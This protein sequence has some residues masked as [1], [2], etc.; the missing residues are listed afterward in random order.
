MKLS[1]TKRLIAQYLHLENDDVIDVMVGT[2]LSNRL[3][4]ES[5]VWMAIVGESSGG[6]SQ[7]IKPMAISDA[8]YFLQVDDLTENTFLSG[9]GGKGEN[10]SLLTP[11]MKNNMLVISDLTVIF[12]KS[13]E[14]QNAILSQF[15]M[16]ADGELTKHTGSKG[17]L[18]WQGR[19]GVLAGCTPAI[20][21]SF[22]RVSDM[23]DR[24]MMYRLPPNDKRKALELALSR[25][26]S[27]NSLNNR[28]ADIFSEYMREVVIKTRDLPR[29]NLTPEITNHI[30]EISEFA[31]Q[32]R[33]P[34]SLDYR[35]TILDKPASAYP[36]RTALQLAAIARTLLLLQQVEPDSNV[37]IPRILDHLAWSLADD[38]TRSTLEV[39]SALEPGEVVTRQQVA[40]YIGLPTSSAGMF[41][42]R[43]LA[44]GIL[45]RTSDAG[46]EFRLKS[47]SDRLLLRRMIGGKSIVIPKPRISYE[48]NV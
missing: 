45:E 33:T 5:V 22:Q 11:A 6:K 40:D 39:F 18:T 16:I 21:R 31:E 47:S 44:R 46:L 29:P 48:T 38:T 10:Y 4:K 8:D 27:G 36:I 15:R 20:Y 42:D 19:M 12:S 14:T 13:E 3:G 30:F 28:M 9:A 43:L 23:G 34:I 25:E 26:L 35:G 2:T 41:V 17:A 37:N 32:L 24:F 7:L 1:D